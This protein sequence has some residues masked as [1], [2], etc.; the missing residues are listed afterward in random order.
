MPVKIHDREY[1]TVA[2]RL[3]EFHKKYLKCS[4]KT[5]ILGEVN[6]TITMKATIW[7][8]YE[9]PRWCYT[10][11]ASETI[12]QGMI[13]KTSA[14]E[15]AETSCIGRA[16]ASAGF[17][18]SE[19]ASADEVANALKKQENSPSQSHKTA[20]RSDDSPSTEVTIEEAKRVKITNLLKEMF[21]Q[22]EDDIELVKKTVQD[23]LEEVTSFIGKD[24]KRMF[25]RSTKELKGKWLDNTLKKVEELHGAY[26]E[27]KAGLGELAE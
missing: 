7:P 5:R 20:P 16:L 14:L 4:I 13:N 6:G 21:T 11:H 24:N 3:N 25:R 27:H 22:P 10:G 12:G 15:N 9:H 17:I 19:F 1:F 18:G 26:L 2:E 23:Q 8:D